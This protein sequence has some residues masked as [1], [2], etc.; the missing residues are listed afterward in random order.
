MKLLLNCVSRYS[1]ALWGST[2]HHLVA[3][4]GT[5]FNEVLLWNPF[6]STNSRD[7]VDFSSSINTDVAVNKRLKG[8]EVSRINMIG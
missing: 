4:V 8:H 7:V 6:H 2:F 1:A 3:A 5:V